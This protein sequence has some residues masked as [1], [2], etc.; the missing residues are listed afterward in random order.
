M[1]RWTFCDSVWSEDFV[2]DD[3]EMIVTHE[4]GVRGVFAIVTVRKIAVAL[5]VH[6]AITGD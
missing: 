5:H 3:G 4:N 1:A 2:I 6:V